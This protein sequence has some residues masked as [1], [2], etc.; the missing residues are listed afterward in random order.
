VSGAALLLAGLLAGGAFAVWLP[1]RA[2]ALE[3]AA[4]GA[5]FGALAASWAAWLAVVAA[6]YATAAV[7]APALLLGIAALLA[8]AAR[9]GRRGGSPGALPPA[10]ETWLPREVRLCWALATLPA[11]AL[12]ARLF[13]THYLPDRDGGWGSAG[14][15][16][17]DLALHASLAS[18]FAEQSRFEWSLPV[19]H[20][21]PLNYPFLPDF[22]S[23]VL[24]RGGISLRWA[25]LAP[26]LLLAF[27][28][29]QLLFLTAWRA[30]GSGR[31]GLFA[32]LLVLLD[33]SA[34]G[35]AAAWT[36]WRG[37]GVSVGAFLAAMPRDYAH[38]P[39][40]N[41]RFSNFVTDALLP[42]RGMLAGMAT[43]LVAVMLLRGAWE[44]AERRTADGATSSPSAPR[45]LLAAAGAL[46]GLGRETARAA[47]SSGCCRRLSGSRSPRRSSPGSSRTR[48]SPSCAGGWAG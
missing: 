24:H 28:L 25:L 23:G 30:T 8:T 26:S 14:S 47:S 41:L 9:R 31:G 19:L 20:G 42:Q 48:R 4:A 45:A 11:S 3:R 5:V 29:V 37:S 2:T 22:L 32:T 18:R 43:V 33:G 39:A 35:L 7:L 6:G 17:G 10:R 27:A 34:A 1:Q 38:V 46:L 15:T 16:W 36:E 12:L 44:A 40:I 21:A 13:S